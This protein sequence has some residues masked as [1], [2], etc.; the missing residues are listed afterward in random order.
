[1]YQH[2]QRANGMLDAHLKHTKNNVYR[3]EAEPVILI[4]DAVALPSQRCVLVKVE[5]H[6]V[7][8]DMHH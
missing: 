8:L 1:M 4:D 6:C 3:E 2:L 7:R 5:R